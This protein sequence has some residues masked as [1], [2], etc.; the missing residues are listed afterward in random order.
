MDGS[1]IKKG[2][3][4]FCAVCLITTSC[5][6]VTLSIDKVPKNTP[7][8]AQIYITGNFNNWNPGDPSYVMKLDEKANQ[9]Y[10]DL[11]IGFGN[12]AYKFTRGDWTTVETDACGGELMNRSFAY[13]SGTRINDTIQ[14]WAD[15]N[16]ENCPRVVLVI[17]KVPSNTPPNDYLY[18][19]GDIN[20]W[21]CD[22]KRYRFA[23]QAN[24]TYVLNIPRNSDKLNYKITRGQWETAELS[25]RG[26]EQMQRELIFGKQDTVFISISSWA[27]MPLRRVYTRTIVLKSIPANTP[28]NSKF[29]F[30]SNL[31]G[32][33]PFD[34]RVVF[35]KTIDGKPAI[36]I[37]YSL[38][39]I[40][41]YKITRGG[42]ER[43]E[44]A[45]NFTEIEDRIIE[46]PSKDTLYLT[47]EAWADMKPQL[48][49]RNQQKEIKLQPK[50]APLEPK[51]GRGIVIDDYVKTP[52]PPLQ[53]DGRKKVF[54]ILDKLPEY[55]RN[56]PVFLAGDFNDW[57][58]NDPK[59]V[60]R[61]LPNGK[62]FMLLRLND[63]AQHEFKITRGSWETEEANAQR[64]KMSN[65]VIPQGGQDD[66]IH[67]RIE[68]WYDE[69]EQKKLTL[70]LTAPA[71]TPEN[72]DVYLA[73]DFNDWLAN[74]EK[75][76]FTRIAPNK[77]VY[78]ITD[79]S[80]RYNYYK[81]SRGSWET[82][83]V[84][85][86]GRIPGNQLFNPQGRDTIRLK[87]ERW[88]DF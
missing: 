29:Y 44:S 57:Q 12:I 62:K 88:K 37:S 27:D 7:Q 28:A 83:A 71:N 39:E 41:A 61:D 46:E 60:F 73:G 20:G 33:N 15:L 8:G 80:R 13:A 65:R 35:N 30:A 3:W 84:T 9:Y 5:K 51:L 85:K 50:R 53:F 32:W 59:M 22:N 21:Q 38:N 70:L 82:E 25:D 31:N 6:R 48:V 58:E 64:E 45:P 79:F 87:I 42:W 14:G 47:I 24:G 16:P 77:F 76:K 74:Q 54:I 78:T 18:L 2:I 63:R 55:A 23:K 11:P 36:T 75:Y 52:V 10:I 17:E 86:S 69:T 67:I 4:L 68:S 1:I 40:V 26:N 43:V 19:G 81:I 56:E 72:S 34:G 49:K 66:T